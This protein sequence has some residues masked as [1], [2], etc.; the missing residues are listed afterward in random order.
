MKLR[1]LELK[2]APFMLE[3]MHDES[4]VK[5]MQTNFASKTIDDCIA[6]IQNSQDCLSDLNLAI[7]NDDD[8]YMG[9]VS[10][11]HIKNAIAE[12]AI[13]VR[14]AAMGQ[15]YSA[16]GMKEIIKIGF[17]NLKLNTIYWC[18]SPDNKRA[19]RFYDKNGYQKISA[20]I[21]N[22]TLC[23][24]KGYSTEQVTTYIW[25]HAKQSD[26]SSV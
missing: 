16:Y 12:F 11:K 15:G 10:L 9:T 21:L 13:I 2:D 3:W 17:S 23:T 4:V 14:K 7:V 26:Y 5:N 18:V 6:F 24:I 20:E 8:T 19:I 1:K 22:D 25:Y